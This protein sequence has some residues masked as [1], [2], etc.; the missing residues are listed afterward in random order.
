MKS[1]TLSVV[2]SILALAAAQPLE[3]RVLVI[4]TV[5][6]V[7]VKTVDITTTIWVDPSAPTHAALVPG[8]AHHANKHA[9]TKAKPA[10]VPVPEAQPQPES[11][12]EAAALPKVNQQPEA[13][14]APEAQ[15]QSQPEAAAL[16]EMDQQPEAD[17]D[18]APV[19]PPVQQSPP[20]QQKSAVEHQQEQEQLQELQKQRQKEMEQLQKQHEQ[21]QKQKEEG[22]PQPQQQQ[23][24][25]PPVIPQPAK[26][27]AA[28][29]QPAA[30][31]QE[32]SP[33]A[34][35]IP[36]NPAPQTNTASSNSGNCGEVGGSCSGDITFYDTGLGACGWTNDGT[37]ENVFALAHGM[38]GAQSN[39]N[40]FCGRQAEVSLNGK[41]V[42]GTLVDKCGGCEG[43]DIDLSHS[44]FQALAD[45]GK[46]RIEGVKWHF[47]D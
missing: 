34:P 10:P 20:V 43:Q 24:Q 40:P 36:N 11:Q 30:P 42:I 16:P 7:V 8:H 47:I 39:G 23:Q 41:T 13:D 31:V 28:A 6:D 38:M 9:H 1:L 21:D 33:P 29:P 27:A 2:A 5:T 18:P 15:P 46:G 12:P 37:T 25:P 26:A 32:A 14:P 19:T 17:P 45:E 35:Q 44:M 4:E 22:Q 3:K